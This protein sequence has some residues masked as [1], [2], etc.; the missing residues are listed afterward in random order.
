[1][2]TKDGEIKNVITHIES[3]VDKKKGYAKKNN[4]KF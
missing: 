4:I 1:M 2:S 3:I